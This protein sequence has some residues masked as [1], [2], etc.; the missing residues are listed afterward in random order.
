MQNLKLENNPLLSSLT[1]LWNIAEA[2]NI[3]LRNNPQIKSVFFQKLEKING[4]LIVE[5]LNALTDMSFHYANHFGKIQL[6]NNPLL[7]QISTLDK[8]NYTLF[9]THSPQDTALFL[10]KQ[11]QSESM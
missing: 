5:N 10:G 3:I 6:R 1:G 8:L 9:N 2:E 7:N 4:D 11:S